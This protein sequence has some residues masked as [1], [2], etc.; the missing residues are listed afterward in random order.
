MT[1]AETFASFSLRATGRKASSIG[2]LD[3]PFSMDDNDDLRTA[4]DTH[5]TSTHDLEINPFENC[6]GAYL[7]APASGHGS[8]SP[9]RAPRPFAAERTSINMSRN[10]SISSNAS[11]VGAPRTRARLDAAHVAAA[12]LERALES[13]SASQHKQHKQQ[14]QQEPARGRTLSRD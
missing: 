2:S 10:S 1:L 14:R 11:S 9:S 3:T 12:K 13:S 7:S 4:V 5:P 6:F 8:P